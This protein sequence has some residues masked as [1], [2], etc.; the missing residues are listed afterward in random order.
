MERSS[1]SWQR[2]LPAYTDRASPLSDRRSRTHA[3]RQYRGD[4]RP[5]NLSAAT[6]PA[7]SQH[8]W[9]EL[10]VKDCSART[11]VWAWLTEN[12]IFPCSRVENVVSPQKTDTKTIGPCFFYEITIQRGA[13]DKD[14]P[15][16]EKNFDKSLGGN[17]CKGVPG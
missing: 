17:R 16:A 9:P 10:A 4:S 8:I 2:S 15:S 7:P 3:Y 14:Q 5:A 12:D 6:F 11:A 13:E 1:S